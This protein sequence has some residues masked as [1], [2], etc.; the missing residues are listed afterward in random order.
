[1][2]RFAA[3]DVGSNASRLLVVEADSPASV[4]VILSRREPVRMG[5]G[6]FL[7]GKLDPHAIDACVDAMASFAEAMDELEVDEHRAVVTASARD[8]ENSKIL[9]R[10]VRES[11]GE[12][13]TVLPD[14]AARR[15]LEV[16]ALDRALDVW[17]SRD[18]AVAGERAA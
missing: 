10:R 13:R 6:V 9:L 8:A 16:T 3:I 17:P 7:T 18:A 15:I 4:R 14:T 5:H 11:G 2:P 1:M 12:L